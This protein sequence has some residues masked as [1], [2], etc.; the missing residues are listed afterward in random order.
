MPK[1][2]KIDPRAVA[3]RPKAKSTA[4][5][6]AHPPKWISFYQRVEK[7]MPIA[8][9]KKYS[10]YVDREAG[11]FHI[12]LLAAVAAV[13]FSFRTTPKA[14]RAAFDAA[15]RRRLATTVD[16]GEPDKPQ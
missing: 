7:V 16:P 6:A 12:A 14:L 11:S 1:R 2:T 3:F 8:A 13:R 15:F 9:D 5:V 10:K 4:A